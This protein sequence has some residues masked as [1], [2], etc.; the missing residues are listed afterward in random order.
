[1]IFSEISG[2]PETVRLTSATSHEPS[3]LAPSEATKKAKRLATQ[4]HRTCPLILDPLEVVHPSIK[5][6][7]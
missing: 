7:Q 4:T 5:T 2:L 1:M 3:P 6:Q